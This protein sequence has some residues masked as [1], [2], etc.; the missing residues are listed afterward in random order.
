MTTV[1]D[2]NDREM[3][4]QISI[5]EHSADIRLKIIALSKEDL[6]KGAL[7]GMARIIGGWENIKGEEKS[8]EKQ[9]K[10]SAPEESALLAD[11]LNEVL[12]LT[13]IYHA[14]FPEIEIKELT[15]ERITG[16]I[17]GQRIEEFKEEIKA[18][19][20]HGLSIVQNKKGLWEAVILFD[21]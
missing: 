13:D 2:Y 20:Y 11:F 5:L 16:K 12:A 4:Y 19:T 18:V 21:I 6:F 15:E 10:V 1:N 3:S 8:I 14:V 7:E 17:K 9:I